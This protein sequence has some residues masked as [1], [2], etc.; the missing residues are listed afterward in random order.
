[1]N[2][3]CLVIAIC[4]LSI[5]ACKK[6]KEEPS[7]AIETSEAP[8][9]PPPPADAPPDQ[10]RID[11]D[12]IAKELGALTDLIPEVTPKLAA[13][14]CAPAV[15]ADAKLVDYD[16]A[17]SFVTGTPSMDLTE[18]RKRRNADLFKYSRQ[19]LTDDAIWT[20]ALYKW[21]ILLP[22]GAKDGLMIRRWPAD[23]TLAFT[24][25]TVFEPP[26]LI[27]YSQHTFKPGNFE[28]AMYVVDPTARKILCRAPVTLTKHPEKIPETES[29]EEVLNGEF[30]GELVTALTN[31]KV[32]MG[33]PPPPSNEP[34]PWALDAGSH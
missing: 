25:V 18:I 13:E 9:T 26:Q 21:G 3:A 2:R 14:K 6:K 28:G 34:P 24:R 22:A 31:A 23:H 19:A 16:L 29:P 27:D 32:A 11:L 8:P 20:V 15:V 4:A 33:A 1:M 17:R 7:I 5:A 12:A 30:Y 10:D